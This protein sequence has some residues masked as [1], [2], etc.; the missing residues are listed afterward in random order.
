VLAAV[1]GSAGAADGALEGAGRVYEQPC[2]KG[3]R[4]MFARAAAAG[5]V[6][7]AD[8]DYMGEWVMI[9]LGSFASFFAPC[10]LEAL[11]EDWFGRN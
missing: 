6:G 3:M 11:E 9:F 5:G 8:V 10:M 2:G 7:F 1:A 4:E